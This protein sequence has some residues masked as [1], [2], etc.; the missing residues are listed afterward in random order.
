M[1]NT[2]KRHVRQTKNRHRESE[3]S[4][5]YIIH[6]MDIYEALQDKIVRIE[7]MRENFSLFFAYHFGWEFK[8]FHVERMK[9][10]QS[11]KNTFIE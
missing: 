10:M 11:E 9:S 4:F 8:Q 1:T 7:A 5:W 3:G 2:D 6:G